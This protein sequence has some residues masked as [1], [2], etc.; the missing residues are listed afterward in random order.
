MA[1]VNLARVVANVVAV[2]TRTQ[3]V[4]LGGVAHTVDLRIADKNRPA[5]IEVGDLVQATYTE[6]VAVPMECARKQ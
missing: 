6:A 4:T 1:E 5:R 3:T 2:I